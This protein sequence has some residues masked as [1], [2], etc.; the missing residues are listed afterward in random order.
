MFGNFAD[1]VAYLD[2]A[3]VT[4]YVSGVVSFAPGDN[5]AGFNSDGGATETSTISWNN[6]IN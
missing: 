2:S 1:G 3:F 4:R 5:V 6:I